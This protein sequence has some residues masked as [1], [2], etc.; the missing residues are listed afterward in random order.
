MNP[1]GI[2]LLSTG[3]VADVAR[4]N[5]ERTV[6][7]FLLG[8]CL[9]KATE[10]RLE[11]GT[12]VCLKD[13][14]SEAAIKN[15]VYHI[16]AEVISEVRGSL[17]KSCPRS[18]Q[19]G[20]V[21]W[22]FYP[23]SGELS[24]TTCELGADLS[25][26]RRHQ[27]L[28]RHME[29][30]DIPGILSYLARLSDASRSVLFDELD[31]ASTGAIP[32]GYCR[33]LETGINAAIKVYSSST[34]ELSSLTQRELSERELSVAVDSCM[35][36]FAKRKLFFNSEQTTMEWLAVSLTDG[37]S[38]AQENYIVFFLI[39]V[40]ALILGD[41]LKRSFVVD[42][43]AKV[44]F[45]RRLTR[46]YLRGQN[47]ENIRWSDSKIIDLQKDELVR[48]IHFLRG[49]NAK[50]LIQSI[51]ENASRAD[52]H[53]LFR[54]KERD[55]FSALKSVEAL[56]ELERNEEKQRALL[57]KVT[58]LQQ[59]LRK[60]K[61]YDITVKEF[62]DAIKANLLNE[63]L[64]DIG[65]HVLTFLVSKMRDA[66][67]HLISFGFFGPIGVLV[68]WVLWVF[69]STLKMALSIKAE[70]LKD[71]RRRN[72]EMLEYEE[73]ARSQERSS[74]HT[75]E[76]KLDFLRKI[77]DIGADDDVL[78]HN[79]SV[80]FIA[81]ILSDFRS[82]AQKLEPLKRER[83]EVVRNRPGF[84][85][86]VT[87]D[88]I[89]GPRREIDDMTSFLDGG[90]RLDNSEPLL[91]SVADLKTKTETALSIL[92]FQW[93]GNYAMKLQQML[94]DLDTLYNRLKPPVSNVGEQ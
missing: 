32:L 47:E 41:V 45:A 82:T 23:K 8:S 53:K 37:F 19:A 4:K 38:H 21:V 72:E 49:P 74:L 25:V 6:S 12:E 20:S 9:K 14:L 61:E 35:K 94:R 63:R 57:L 67:G 65:A 64:K 34:R 85:M 75:F 5:I 51:S 1:L 88:I 81:Q 7:K 83:Q 44:K 52:V 84:D 26:L 76:Q 22:R 43:L 62:E 60:Q 91:E 55:V 58:E 24:F 68:L 39:M 30:R 77:C 50:D 90:A 69:M 31:R 46:E 56:E 28:L 16:R 10:N 92:Q 87:E 80:N 86:H 17:Q 40:I 11:R 66:S 18:G 29:D 36:K 13:F 73:S 54:E 59:L 70:D 15:A 71:L 78:Q 3:L 89:E 79:L 33:S 93:N 48:C 42:L 2:T 27:K